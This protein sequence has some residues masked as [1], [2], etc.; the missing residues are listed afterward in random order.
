[1]PFLLDIK[2]PP[3]LSFSQEAFLFL[4]AFTGS[5]QVEEFFVGYDVDQESIMILGLAL[6]SQ[7]ETANCLKAES[8]AGSFIEQVCIPGTF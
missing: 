8:A 2:A 6:L 5:G 7:L 4:S 1:M 3:G